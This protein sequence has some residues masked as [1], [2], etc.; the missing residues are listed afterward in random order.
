MIRSQPCRIIYD[1]MFMT[2]KG[3][4]VFPGGSKFVTGRFTIFIRLNKGW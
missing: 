4:V 2:G 1:D 3:Q